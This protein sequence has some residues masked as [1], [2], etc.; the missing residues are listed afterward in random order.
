[1]TKE[2]MGELKKLLEP[3]TKKLGKVDSELAMLKEKIELI[4]SI[5]RR[6]EEINIDTN[7]TKV[8][9]MQM[10]LTQSV[11]TRNIAILKLDG[12]RS[13][14]NIKGLTLLVQQILDLLVTREEF[15]EL[16]KRIRLLESI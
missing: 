5:G 12:E 10:K 8:D 7:K 9:I 11:D 16:K 14:E 2:E 13:K 4:P 6:I 1:M 15:T 3:I